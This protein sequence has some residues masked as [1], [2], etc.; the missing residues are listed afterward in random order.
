MAV[1]VFGGGCEPQSWG[2]GGRRG[3]G[4]YVPFERALVSSYRPSILTF[5]PSLCVSKILLL[6]CSSTPLFP[7]PPLVSPK[8]PHVPLAVGGC[9]LS[10][11]VGIIVCAISF[12]DFQPMWSRSTKVT[13]GGQ[14]DRQTDDMQSQYHT[15]H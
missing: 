10:K 12:Q 15:L 13:D 4:Q 8:F 7:A 11:G 14:T 6:L 5:P 3:S 2:R 9:S 1:E